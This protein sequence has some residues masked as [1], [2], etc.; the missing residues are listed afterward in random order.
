MFGCEF[1][2]GFT[3]FGTALSDAGKQ[4]LRKAVFDFIRLRKGD[5]LVGN[6]PGIHAAELTGQILNAVSE[7]GLI[8]VYYRET[9]DKEV[10]AAAFEPLINYLKLWEQRSDGTIE[11]RKTDWNW[12]DHNYNI[13]FNVIENA[14]YYSALKFCKRLSED[15]GDGRFAEFLDRRIASVARGFRARFW[16]G[17]HFAEG[18]YVDDRANALAVICGLARASD[19][20]GIRK[21]LITVFNSTPYMEYYVL[22]ALCAP[23]V[24]R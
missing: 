19:Y 24:A 18:A 3:Q 15:L 12:V 20:E 2:E 5:V 11:T 4:L 22:E 9:G 6:V 23:Q 14:W 16:K 10:A 17:N 21:V 7:Y 13:D 8:A 1:G